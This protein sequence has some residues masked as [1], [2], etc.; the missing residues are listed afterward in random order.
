VSG[1][2]YVK[3]DVVSLDGGTYIALAATTGE[4]PTTT[5][6]KWQ[7]MQPKPVAATIVKT[8]TSASAANPSVVVNCPAGKV[9]TGGG[10]DTSTASGNLQVI[11]SA[12]TSGGVLATDGQ[13]PDGWMVS[14]NSNAA[15]TI[16]GYVICS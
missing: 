13:V 15:I 2:A 11:R 3:N 8:A 16:T 4:N 7:Q 9:A 14:R 6:A 12:P 1:T 5:P 10:I